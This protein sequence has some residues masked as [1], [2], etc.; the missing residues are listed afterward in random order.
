MAANFSDT[1]GHLVLGNHMPCE[2]CLLGRTVIHCSRCQDGKVA[3]PYHTID[4]LTCDTNGPGI[5]EG[6]KVLQCRTCP[7]PEEQE[8]WCEACYPLVQG[9][10]G[11]DHKWKAVCFREA[12]TERHTGRVFCGI[13]DQGT[14]PT[15]DVATVRTGTDVS[16]IACQPRHQH[17]P[18]APELCHPHGRRG[19]DPPRP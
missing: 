15:A 4:V 12:A 11:L 5:P 13:C 9:E 17:R 18:S 19:A 10:H 1:N 16:R 2:T 8:G 14:Q 7:L 3:I 6:E